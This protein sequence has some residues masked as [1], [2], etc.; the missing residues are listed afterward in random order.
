MTTDNQFDWVEFYKEL[1]SKLLQY[2]ADRA[3]LVDKVK[4]IYE[5]T[6][7]NMPTLE[8]DNQLV[9]LF[10][11]QRTG[12]ERPCHRIIIVYAVLLR[13]STGARPFLS[14]IRSKLSKS[15]YSETSCSNSAREEKCAR[16]RHSVFKVPKKFSIAALS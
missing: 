11:V 3:G 13:I 4:Q 16:Y 8:K 1:A 9:G 5:T 10:P 2:K 14:E 7:I 15:T 6:G 12:K